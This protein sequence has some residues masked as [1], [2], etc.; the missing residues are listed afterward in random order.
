MAEPHEKVGVQIEAI[1][2]QS[3]L[4]GCASASYAGIAFDYRDLQA[5]AR[6]IGRD[7]EPIVSG[8]DDNTIESCH[9]R[10][11]PTAICPLLHEA[12]LDRA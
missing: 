12:S 9:F 4:F 10:P 11:S 8:S 6:Q 2:W 7:R 3:R 5:C 1:A